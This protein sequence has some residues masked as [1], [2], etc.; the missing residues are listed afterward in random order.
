MKVLARFNTPEDHEKLV[1]GIIK[2]KQLRQRIAE[3]R[4]LQAKG[5]RS[6][7]E[8][9]E[10][11]EGKKK[12]DEKTKKR[13]DNAL[14][15]KVKLLLIQSKTRRVARKDITGEKTEKRVLYVSREE[16][17]LCSK[18]NMTFRQYVGIKEKIM[19]EMVKMGV[20]SIDEVT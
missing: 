18:L 19:R 9:E 4:E 16:E 6:W 11:L 5:I 17:E 8:V 1:Q 15:D 10:E 7:G 14:L 3:L 13:D 20:V 2:E 12:K